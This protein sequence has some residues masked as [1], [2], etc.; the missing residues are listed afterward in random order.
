MSSD[1]SSKRQQVNTSDV[2][3]SNLDNLHGD[4]EVSL[5]STFRH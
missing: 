2:R 3:H 1:L 4:D 5:L